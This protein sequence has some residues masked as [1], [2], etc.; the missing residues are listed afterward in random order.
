VPAGAAPTASALLDGRWSLLWTCAAGDAAFSAAA[1][2]ES[3]D[4]FALRN[5]VQA[6]SDAAYTFF[7]QRVP[8]LAGAAPA[9]GNALGVARATGT[10]QSI[11]RAAKTVSNEAQLELASGQRLSITVAGSAVAASP[12]RLD[13]TFLS[14]EVALG[15]PSAPLRLSLPLAL[16][17]PRGAV[18]TTYLDA[19]VRIGRGDKGSV[20]VCARAGSRE[21]AS[22]D[23]MST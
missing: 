10:W 4:P 23:E 13:V 3:S 7:Y 12:T 2:A 8:F 20:F 21:E 9:G 16:L 15:A 19:A 17:S 6:A 14:F 1:G 11:D 22:A 5:A 18:E